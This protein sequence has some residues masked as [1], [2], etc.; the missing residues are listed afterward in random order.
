M[1]SIAAALLGLVAVPPSPS[2][3]GHPPRRARLPVPL[4]SPDRPPGRARDAKPRALVLAALFAALAGIT[5]SIIAVECRAVGQ[6]EAA[7]P[8]MR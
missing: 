1:K 4:A 6:S 8:D 3:E 7:R 2:A 5:L